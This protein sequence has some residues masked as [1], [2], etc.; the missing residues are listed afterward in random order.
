MVGNKE[1]FIHF[2]HENYQAVYMR[3]QEGDEYPSVVL[4]V[5]NG[6]LFYFF[7]VD[8][9]PEVMEE[10]PFVTLDESEEV[11]SFI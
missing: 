10:A 2:K 4:L 7:M 9:E 5:P 8:F 11:V 1:I 6:R 3:K